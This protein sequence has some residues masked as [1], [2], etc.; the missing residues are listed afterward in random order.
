MQLLLQTLFNLLVLCELYQ[1]IAVHTLQIYVFVLHLL[2][3][4]TDKFLLLLLSLNDL[5]RIIESNSEVINRQFL[6]VEHSIK[7]GWQLS[8]CTL[9]LDNVG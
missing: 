3:L 7:Y 9:V 1:K 2:Q 6:T 5:I 4:F 8:E